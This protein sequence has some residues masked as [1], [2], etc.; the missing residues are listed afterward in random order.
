VHKQLLTGVCLVCYTTWQVT[1]AIK[2]YVEDKITKS[3]H[4]FSH[5]VKKIDVTISARGGDTGTHGAK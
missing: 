3:V 4:N 2:Q 5:N 1:D